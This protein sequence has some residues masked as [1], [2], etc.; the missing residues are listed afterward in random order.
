MRCNNEP[1]KTEMGS[2][3]WTTIKATSSNND[4]K[5][6]NDKLRNARDTND[7]N[8]T[9]PGLS[10]EGVKVKTG[11]VLAVAV[12]VTMVAADR[13]QSTKCGSSSGSGRDRG[14]GG[15]NLGSVA[16]VVAIWATSG[17]SSGGSGGIR[18]CF[19]DSFCGSRGGSFKRQDD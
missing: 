3:G 11:A 16:V 2:Q 17:G 13:Q 7:D 8:A 18:C 9:M 12:T 6:H 1:V 15:G 5:N 19:G 10:R 14:C 4:H